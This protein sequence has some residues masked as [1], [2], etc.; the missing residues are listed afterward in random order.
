MI[1]ACQREWGDQELEKDV[2][3]TWLTD[4]THELNL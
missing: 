2:S 3:G 4:K 1:E